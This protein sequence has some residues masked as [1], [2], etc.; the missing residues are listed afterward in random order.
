MEVKR[1]GKSASPLQAARI[2]AI[3]AVGGAVAE[4]VTSKAQA[5]EILA[6]CEQEHQRG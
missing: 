1:P 6:S 5:G 2:D 4:V 3:R